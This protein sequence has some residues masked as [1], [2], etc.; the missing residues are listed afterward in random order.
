MSQA[1]FFKKMLKEAD[2][3]DAVKRLRVQDSA[4]APLKPFYEVYMRLFSI[5][6]AVVADLVHLGCIGEAKRGV[7]EI[8]SLR[9]PLVFIPEG[10]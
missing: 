8:G 7:F 4:M 5:S 2:H 10:L 6:M 1:H 9:S 3:L